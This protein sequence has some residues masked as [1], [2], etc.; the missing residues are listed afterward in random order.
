MPKNYTFFIVNEDKDDL[1]QLKKLLKQYNYLTFVGSENTVSSGVEEALKT[2]PDIIFTGIKFNKKTGF[3]IIEAL[4]SFK[5]NP[6]IV[7]TE[8]TDK[9]T[10]DAIN[11]RP[12]AYLL[13]PYTEKTIKETLYKIVN[14]IEA[15]SVKRTLFQFQASDIVINI[16]D[17]V[18]CKIADGETTIVLSSN[19]KYNI[20]MP[21]KD[22]IKKFYT[23]NFYQC[24]RSYIIN[25]DYLRKIDR[26][27]SKVTLV[28]GEDVFSVS[29]SPYGIKYLKSLYS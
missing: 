20:N 1:K 18:Y 21:L 27:T 13:S 28:K 6:A 25:L 3:D 14:N 7:F 12:Y 2:K 17:V 16:D 5:L 11:Y 29:I 8:K 10:L 4:Q 22:L 9:Y 15:V 19:E 24:Y 26:K 23:H